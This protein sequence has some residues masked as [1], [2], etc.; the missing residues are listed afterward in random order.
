MLWI[1]IRLANTLQQGYIHPSNNPI[2]MEGREK[3]EED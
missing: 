2:C 1:G 3:K